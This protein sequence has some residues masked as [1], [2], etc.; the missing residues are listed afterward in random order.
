MARVRE[1]EKKED[2]L[3]QELSEVEEKEKDASALK[4]TSTGMR[5]Y[6]YRGRER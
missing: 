4:I 2:G 1:M 6:V 5:V 3:R